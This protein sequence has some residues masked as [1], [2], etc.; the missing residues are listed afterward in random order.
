MNC[1]CYILFSSSLNKYY[2]GSTIDIDRR[3]EEHNRGKKN[4]IKIS[5][6]NNQNVVTEKDIYVTCEPEAVKEHSYYRSDRYKI[7]TDKIL[8]Y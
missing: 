7:Q 1:C 3:I 2:V 5:V 4:R 8:D 6:Q